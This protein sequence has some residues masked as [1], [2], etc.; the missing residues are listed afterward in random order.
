VSRGRVL[1]PPDRVFVQRRGPRLS[2]VPSITINPATTSVVKGSLAS[3]GRARG[4]PDRMFVQRRMPSLASTTS[5]VKG[6]HASRGRAI[7]PTDRLY[8]QRRLPRLA[9]VPP[10]T[11]NPATRGQ[12][13][14]PSDRQTAP[15]R[16]PSHNCATQLYTILFTA[17]PRCGP[18][19][20][21]SHLPSR[22]RATFPE[23]PPAPVPRGLFFP[24][25]LT[26]LPRPPIRCAAARAT[27]PRPL[28]GPLRAPQP[29]LVSSTLSVPFLTDV[30][31]HRSTSTR[32]AHRSCSVRLATDTRCSATLSPPPA[33]RITPSRPECALVV[34]LSARV[35]S[36]M[37]AVLPRRSPSRFDL[38]PPPRCPKT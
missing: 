9:S 3:R 4:P 19:L 37:T 7:G 33:I 38:R 20:P 17:T 15:R 5:A 32:L 31:P 35:G 25:P 24:S 26:P 10:I 13:P 16:G 34:G 1:G 12:P 23:Y 28:P 27:S 29:A 22:S 8:V 14:G 21:T 11:I 36:P 2:S 6:R 18:A 30:R